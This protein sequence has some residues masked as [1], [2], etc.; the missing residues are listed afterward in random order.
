MHKIQCGP[1]TMARH[2][3]K[4]VERDLQTKASSHCKRSPHRVLRFTFQEGGAG[5]GARTVMGFETRWNE[6]LLSPRGQCLGLLKQ[7]SNAGV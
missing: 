4:Y 5:H 2:A 1:A 3:K 6:V 7:D